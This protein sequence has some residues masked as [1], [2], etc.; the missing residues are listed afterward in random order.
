M[1]PVHSIEV[2]VANWP[3]GLLSTAASWASV[4][5]FVVL[6]LYLI[7]INKQ[8]S[9]MA[10]FQMLAIERERAATSLSNAYEAVA[11]LSGIYARVMTLRSR[12][13]EDIL[14]FSKL[15]PM[16]LSIPE[17]HHMRNLITR[18]FDNPDLLLGVE[19]T[20][21]Y[22]PLLQGVIAEA[23]PTTDLPIIQKRFGEML[24]EVFKQQEAI[25]DPLRLEVERCQT[26]LEEADKRSHEAA[27]FLRRK[28]GIRAWW[29]A[30]R[31]Q[32]GS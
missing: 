15:V 6:T 13:L 18:A 10:K 16:W 25:Q 20:Y 1:A 23:D 26:Q 28:R 27:A 17:Q 22:W 8:Q 9:L 19:Q 30:R 29:Q 2:V 32:N 4:L 21:M 12:P 5:A 24:D 14:S 3:S 31:A 11:A 7:A